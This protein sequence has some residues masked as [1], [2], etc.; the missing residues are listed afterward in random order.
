VEVALEH[1]AQDPLLFLHPP[2]AR[3]VECDRARGSVKRE[4]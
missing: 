1:L 4:A 3:C 2:S